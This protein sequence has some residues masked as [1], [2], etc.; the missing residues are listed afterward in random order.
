[1]S[2]THLTQRKLDPSNSINLARGDVSIHVYNI[3]YIKDTNYSHTRK[4][5]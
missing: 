3:G 1:M 5:F 2:A 4:H